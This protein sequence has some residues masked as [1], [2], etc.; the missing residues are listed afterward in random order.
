MNKGI[1]LSPAQY[2]KI[3]DAVDFINRMK[4]SGKFNQL[5]NEKNIVTPGGSDLRCW[6]GM[7]T[8]GTGDTESNMYTS[9]YYYIESVYEPSATGANSLRYVHSDGN[10]LKRK[11][12]ALNLW[13]ASPRG[14][15]GGQSART[16]PGTIVLVYQVKKANYDATLN[17]LSET[18]INFFFAPPISCTTDYVDFGT[19]NAALI[20]DRDSVIGTTSKTYSYTKN[21]SVVTDNFAYGN[22]YPQSKGFRYKMMSHTPGDSGNVTKLHERQ[23]SIDNAGTVTQ[24]SAITTYNT[25]RVAVI[26]AIRLVGGDLEYKTTTIDVLYK[27][28]ES[29]WMPA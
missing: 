29:G 21:G 2:D 3:M 27:G 24:A 7:V 13:E 12:K 8:G 11:V 25:Q 17:Q 19:A 20:W 4:S 9:A 28:T 18:E 22:R 10:P 15:E 23:L 5:I 16:L 1:I 26:T 14:S 6:L